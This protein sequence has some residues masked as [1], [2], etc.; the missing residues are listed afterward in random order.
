M[1][2]FMN[3]DVGLALQDLYVPPEFSNCPDEYRTSDTK[4]LYC[5]TPPNLEWCKYLKNLHLAKDFR[6]YF[7]AVIPLILSI[8]AIILNLAFAIVSTIVLFKY[9]HSSKKKFAFLLSRSISTVSVQILFY[10]VLISWKTGGF[11]YS[12]AVIFLLVGC[13]SF[14]TLTGTYLA[15]STLLYFAVVHPFWYRA[16]ITML[17]CVVLIVIIWVI[18]IVFSICVGIYGATLFY[19]ETAPITCRYE[20]CQKPLA[21][22]LVVVLAVCYL[23]VL[24][25]Y[26]LMFLRMHYRNQ[27]VAKQGNITRQPSIERNT[28]AMNRLS[29]N[30]ISFAVSKL[31][32][33]IVSIVAAANLEHLAS[34]GN[35]EKSPC[36]TFMNGSLYFQ[37]ELLASIAAIIWLIGMISDPI[38]NA[39]SDPNIMKYLRNTYHRMRR[40][41]FSGTEKDVSFNDTDSD[42]G[43]G[44][45]EPANVP[46]CDSTDNVLPLS[47]KTQ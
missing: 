32:I 19:P 15:L 14:L 33:L 6:K 46:G 20:S 40:K 44:Q 39:M 17:R 41:F 28:K 43:P 18:S 29:F 34:L 47:M 22:V 7:L 35:G 26:L 38:I 31:P 10:V 9:G 21:I 16:N 23:T 3:I 4:Y 30:L 25:V 37:V 11:E 24:V 5:G 2:D 27:K 1:I 8:V 42:S 36:K 13:L 45:P 12:S